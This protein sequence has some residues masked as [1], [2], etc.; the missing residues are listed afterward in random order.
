MHGLQ[1]H[2][3][4]L[5]DSEYKSMFQKKQKKMDKI[6]D[7]LQ[8]MSSICSK[9]FREAE[10]A[11]PSFNYYF[12]SYLKEGGFNIGCKLSDVCFLAI[13][14]YQGYIDARGGTKFII[15]DTHVIQ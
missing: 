6:L 5:G 1:K 10:A 11:F 7:K 13:R 12:A 15:G 8:E 4:S 3:S 14:C 2:R 9:A